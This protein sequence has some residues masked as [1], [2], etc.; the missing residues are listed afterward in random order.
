MSALSSISLDP[1]LDYSVKP[2]V[3]SEESLVSQRVSGVAVPV[4]SKGVSD[5]APGEMPKV[6]LVDK[7]SV[8][9]E[10][11]TRFA[12]GRGMKP[13]GEVEKGLMDVL[14]G[15]PSRHREKF[16]SK[17]LASM[18]EHILKEQAKFL[19]ELSGGNS[20][21]ELPMIGLLR[22]IAPC[23]REMFI[24]A[25]KNWINPMVEAGQNRYE[26]YAGLARGFA[27]LSEDPAIAQREANSMMNNGTMNYG[28][29]DLAISRLITGY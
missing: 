22:K 11:A 23:N 9:R 2:S 5:V 28:L 8:L 1:Q 14:R 13:G 26:V 24:E 21:L 25:A 12:A 3:V 10:Q 27:A 29:L 15:I 7:E 20:L 17:V 16:M 19:I 4:I 18:P 6:S